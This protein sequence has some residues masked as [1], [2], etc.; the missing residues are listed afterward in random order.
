MKKSWVPLQ[1]EEIVEID[2][3]KKRSKKKE[4]NV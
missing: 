1:F 3:K 2:F 4:K